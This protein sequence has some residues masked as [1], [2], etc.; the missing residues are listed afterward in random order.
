MAARSVFV[1]Q[2]PHIKHEDL[3]IYTTTQTH[4]LGQKAG[5]ILGVRCRAL[6]VTVEDN[7]ALRG[8]TLLTA[9]EEDSKRGK[10]PFIIGEKHGS[11]FYS[12]CDEELSRLLCSG[13][14]WYNFFGC[15]RSPRRD[16]S[17]W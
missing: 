2:H 14:R 15:H 1:K 8:S 17:S 4:S 11:E 13:Y 12:A 3:V 6:E 7:F 9:L 16:W 5:L 10:H